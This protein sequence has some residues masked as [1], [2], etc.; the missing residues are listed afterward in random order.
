LKFSG[1]LHLIS[2][3]VDIWGDILV[4]DSGS[5][6]DET[7]YRYWKMTD[8]RDRYIDIDVSC[9]SLYPNPYYCHFDIVVKQSIFI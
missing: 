9:P 6:S 3:S 5:I 2:I 8:I 7:R 4:S 1:D